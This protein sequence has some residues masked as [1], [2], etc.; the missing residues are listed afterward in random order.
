MVKAIIIENANQAWQDWFHFSD[1][2]M[3]K[4]DQC[5]TVFNETSLCLSAAI[6][7][8]GIAIG[9]FLALGA[10]QSGALFA[11]FK[12]GIESEEAY[13]LLTP[14]GRRQ[15]QAEQAFEAWLHQT[16]AQYQQNIS[17][18]FE[19]QQIKVISRVG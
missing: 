7:G 9:S 10:L 4:L 6:S 11:P 18:Y 3:P 1:Y 16:V 5:S 13:C 19:Q 14:A 2:A 15:S 8:G 12:V 17:Q